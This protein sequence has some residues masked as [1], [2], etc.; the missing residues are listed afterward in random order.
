M[1]KVLLFAC[2]IV[3]GLKTS[4]QHFNQYCN[5]VFPFCLD[6]PGN[7]VR[8]GESKIGY[9][10]FFKT[11]E[12]STL[13]VFGTYNTE[14]ENLKS[15]FNRESAAL[16]SD[17]T[18]ASTTQLPTIELAEMQENNYTIIYQN[19][20]NSNLIYRKL[21]NNNWLSIEM[22]YP[23]AKAKEYTEKAKRMIASFK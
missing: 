9:G 2:M 7:F 10:Q 8:Q 14:Q 13:S 15:R 17:S 11:K 5:S 4:A 16:T 1:K 22:Q 20:N 23:N 3:L 6:I 19:Q 18:L 21:E 12:G